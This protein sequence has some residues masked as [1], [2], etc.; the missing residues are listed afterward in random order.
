MA[1]V[2]SDHGVTVELLRSAITAR[3]VF[4]KIHDVIHAAAITVA[5]E[6]ILE[7]RETLKRPSLAAGNTPDRL[8]KPRD[9]PTHRRVQAVAL[10]RP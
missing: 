5:L 2:A 10:G 7:P 9:G 4:G 8:Y 1:R 3:D 6:E